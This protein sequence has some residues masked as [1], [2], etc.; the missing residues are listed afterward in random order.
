MCVC[1]CVCV[2]V[3]TEVAGIVQMKKKKIEI[4]AIIIFTNSDKYYPSRT[5][6]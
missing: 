4:I 2:C 6:F 3:L 1:V 5:K